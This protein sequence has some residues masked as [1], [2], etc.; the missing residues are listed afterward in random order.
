MLEDQH[1]VAK[2]V[3]AVTSGNGLVVSV[4][5]ELTVGEGADE[6]QQGGS[7]EVEVGD[8]GVDDA[9]TETRV[10]EEVGWA[11]EGDDGAAWAWVLSG[12]LA[13]GLQDADGGCADGDHAVAGEFGLVDLLGD[14]GAEFAELGVDGVLFDVLLGNGAEGVE[15]DV[16]GDEGEL[17][18]QVAE[19]EEE[20]WGEVEAGG[21]CGDG[22]RLPG[23]DRLV[24]FGV[25]KGGVDVGRKGD[26]TEVLEEVIDGGVEADQAAS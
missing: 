11:A 17:Y 5:D 1:G 10:D 20:F 15:A 2:A 4:E 14:F 16:E 12:A 7:G 3:E 8:Q 9:E 13:G 24:A 19:A 26:L 18:T 23:V 22:S 6:H 21:G 25:G